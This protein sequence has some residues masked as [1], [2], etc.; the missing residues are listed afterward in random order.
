MK[1]LNITIDK[2]TY[3]NTRLAAFVSNS[4]ISAIIRTA[5]RDWFIKHKLTANKKLIFNKSDVSEIKDILKSDDF[6]DLKKVKQELG[7]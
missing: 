2:E 3:E 4:N 5:L 6:I 7:V 1:R